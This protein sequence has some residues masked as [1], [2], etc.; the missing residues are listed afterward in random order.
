MPNHLTGHLRL[1]DLLFWGRHGDKPF[2][3]QGGNRFQVDIDLTVHLEDAVQSDSLEDSVDLSEAYRIARKH[4]EGD[5][6]TLIETVAARMA[7]DLFSLKKV[8]SVTVRVRKISPPIP[9]MTGGMMEAE[10]TRGD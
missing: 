9:G 4:L 1:R 5:S 6:C 3:R 2:E 8:L 10:V 7:E